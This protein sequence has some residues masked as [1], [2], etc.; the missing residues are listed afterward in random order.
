M[1]RVDRLTI[2]YGDR[3]ALRDVTLEVPNG[4]VTAIVGPSGCGKSSLL[5]AINRLTDL[6]PGAEVSG[7]IEVDSQE[8]RGTVLTVLLPLFDIQ[9]GADLPVSAS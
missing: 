7:S 5:Q 1:I 9:H 3:V 4:S 2:R 8:G 6:V